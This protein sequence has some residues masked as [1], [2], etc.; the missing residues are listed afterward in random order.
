MTLKGPEFK[1]ALLLGVVAVA[2]MAF[3]LSGVSIV[4]SPAATWVNGRTTRS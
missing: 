3:S 4:A 2:T 1:K